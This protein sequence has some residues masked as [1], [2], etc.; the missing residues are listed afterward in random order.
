MGDGLRGPTGAKGERGNDGIDGTG[1]GTGVGARGPTGAKGEP[2]EQG[3]SAFKLWQEQQGN[4][5]KTY[6]DYISQFVATNDYNNRVGKVNESLEYVST[7]MNILAAYTSRLISD[8]Y[9]NDNLEQLLEEYK[10]VMYNQPVSPQNV[11]PDTNDQN[12]G[13]HITT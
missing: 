1:T 4:E 11:S 5:N 7:F 12:Q 9:G 2:G 3:K 8:H 6:S 10:I 13:V